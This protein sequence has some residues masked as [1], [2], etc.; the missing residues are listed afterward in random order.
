M[1]SI[2]NSETINTFIE[3]MIRYAGEILILLIFGILIY[4]SCKLVDAIIFCIG[5]IFMY[6]FGNIIHGACVIVKTIIKYVKG[7]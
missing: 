7:E 4:A 5:F 3:I 6:F 1:I 2:I